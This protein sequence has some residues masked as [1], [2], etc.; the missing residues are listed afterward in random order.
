MNGDLL[1]QLLYWPMYYS[2]QLFGLLSG[3]KLFNYRYQ[4]LKKK[5]S[6]WGFLGTR[7]FKSIFYPDFLI[8]LYKYN[9][10]I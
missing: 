6:W 4:L 2:F 7:K 3:S 5:E 8:I 9:K 1:I 10:E